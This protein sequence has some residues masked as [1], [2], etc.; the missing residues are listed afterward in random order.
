MD[1]NKV[2]V[3]E[4]WRMV[5]GWR[6]RELGSR[7][8]VPMSPAR[9]DRK[10]DSNRSPVERSLVEKLGLIIR[11]PVTAHRTHFEVQEVAPFRP[12]SDLKKRALPAILARPASTSPPQRR[13]RLQSNQQR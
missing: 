6:F 2:A 4:S 1:L 10:A 9:T 11:L 13:V 7:E 12:T 5:G 8:R 3:G